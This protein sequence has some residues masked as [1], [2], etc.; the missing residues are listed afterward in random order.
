VARLSA[1]IGTEFAVV[2]NTYRPT[3]DTPTRM[4]W[5]TEKV[6]GII[7]SSAAQCLWLERLFLSIGGPGAWY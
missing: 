1:A 3:V 5:N 6:H 7:C 4:I 2:V